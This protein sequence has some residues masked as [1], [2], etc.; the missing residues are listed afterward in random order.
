MS[1][2][3]LRSRS[4][5]AMAIGLAATVSLVAASCGG[6][7]GSASS[8]TSTPPTTVPPVSQPATSA[9]A[10]ST[11]TIST[12]ESNEGE[13]LFDDNGQ[14]LYIYTP[15]ADRAENSPPTCVDDCATAWPPV[16][17]EGEPTAGS[18]VDAALLGTVAR[19]DGTT[20]VT[21]KGQPLYRFTSDQPGTTS[22]QGVGGVWFLVGPT[23]APVSPGS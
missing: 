6:D 15:D 9:P 19:S 22:G 20:Q 2:S 16:T 14:A 11:V 5:R 7:D 3:H 8:T 12:G 10:G 18:G 1:S 13:I 17:V 4:L 23:G 21:Y